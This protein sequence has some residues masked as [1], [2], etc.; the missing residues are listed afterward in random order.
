MP[1]A[2]ATL[3]PSQV[4][5]LPTPGDLQGQ[6]AQGQSFVAKFGTATTPGAPGQQAALSDLLGAGVTLIGQAVGGTGQTLIRTMVTIGSAV[7]AGA[8]VGGPFGAAGGALVGAA[9]ALWNALN[10]TP[11]VYAGFIVQ[12]TPGANRLASLVAGWQGMNEGLVSGAAQG[13]S[14]ASYLLTKAPPHTTL[15]PRLLWTLVNGADGADGGAG[16][17]MEIGNLPPVDGSGNP[18][19]IARSSHGDFG[20]A[21]WPPSSA[22][23][24]DAQTYLGLVQAIDL[25]VLWG[26]PQPGSAATSTADY[27]ASF[28]R[29]SQQGS[30]TLWQ[31]DTKPI[32]GPHGM[33][34]A[35]IMASALRRAP[36]PLYFAQDL[37][38]GASTSS[39]GDTY[40][41]VMNCAAASALATVLGLLAVGAKTQAIVTELELQ[42]QVLDL[43]DYSAGPIGGWSATIAQLEADL[44]P[45]NVKS[46]KDAGHPYSSAE[47]AHMQAELAQAKAHKTPPPIP[48]LFRQ[49][50]EDYIALAHM[51]KA[52]PKASMRDVVLANRPYEPSLGA[53][54]APSSGAHPSAAA[55]A[56]GKV[57]IQRWLN[58][59]LGGGG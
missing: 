30:Y 28:Q 35:D 20:G 12:A 17:Y 41:L 55:Q 27:E 15:R 57:T 11:P 34:Q 40:T 32:V 21:A 42:Q 52:N 2:T 13:E 29:L 51:E 37:Y 22:D 54:S 44:S 59:Y 19:P 53:S 26:W 16:S 47:L 39:A 3:A 23:A 49:L 8:A 25:S 50:L 14:F 4:Q 31:D 7:A 58:Y 10:G 45:A 36:D 43:L 48:H 38:I 56:A 24:Q 1:S 5:P 6:L 18:M 9:Q 46:A 33:S